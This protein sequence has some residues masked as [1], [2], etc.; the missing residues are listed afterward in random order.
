MGD[1]SLSRSFRQ[2]VTVSVRT[3]IRQKIKNI[4]EWRAMEI[5]FG[6]AGAG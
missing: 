3:L 6:S 4:H 5:V 2:P 1:H